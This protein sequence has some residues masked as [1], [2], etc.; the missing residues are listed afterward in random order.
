[1][2]AEQGMVLADPGDRVADRA[3]HA[4]SGP[5]GRR[6]SSSIATAQADSARQLSNEEVA[7]GV[8]LRLPLGI[9]EGARL[10]D[11]VFDLGEASAVRILGA[12]VEHLAGIAECRAR[13]FGSKAALRPRYP[14]ALGGDE[15][16]RVELPAG[17]GESRAR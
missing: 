13:Q 3:G 7:F 17:V 8:R 1:M 5:L 10:R 12:C 16:E 11:V 4:D 9:S 15:V 6:R 2:L 14:D